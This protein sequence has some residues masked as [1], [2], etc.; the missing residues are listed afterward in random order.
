VEEKGKR[1]KILRNTYLWLKGICAY[2]VG[3]GVLWESMLTLLSR[4]N[5]FTIEV[6]GN[7]FFGPRNIDPLWNIT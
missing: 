3:G 7:T 4:E 5:I 6:E 2:L 1:G